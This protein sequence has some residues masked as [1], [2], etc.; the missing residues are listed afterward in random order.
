[1]TQPKS[2]RGQGWENPPE[3]TLNAR[4][5]DAVL[6]HLVV[7]KTSE[8]SVLQDIEIILSIGAAHERPN[9]AG[10]RR[11]LDELIVAAG[12]FERSLLDL[13]AAT[14]DDLSRD[15]DQQKVS[16]PAEHERWLAKYAEREP[17]ATKVFEVLAKNGYR[18]VPPPVPAALTEIA[19][20]AREQRD[21]LAKAE[22]R[23]KR[24]LVMR[25]RAIFRLGELFH[26]YDTGSAH[27]YRHRMID[28]I[29]ASLGEGKLPTPKGDEKVWALVPQNFRKARKGAPRTPPK[30]PTLAEVV[31]KRR[32][33]STAMGSA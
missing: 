6:E 3:I 22:T 27:N 31:A 13:D 8:S 4:G 5:R 15:V 24:P 2:V 14:W 12:R 29:T 33:D 28:F 16:L 10:R 17:K 20:A 9:I 32:Q 19:R 30:Y 18:V 25:D 23:G 1:M 11:L 21:R 26:E 7:L